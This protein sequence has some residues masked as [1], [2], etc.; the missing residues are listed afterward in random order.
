MKLRNS[1]LFFGV[2]AALTLP[3]LLANIEEKRTVSQ[4]QKAYS[5]LD[6]GFSLAINDLGTVDNWPADNSGYR[7]SYITNNIIP[8]YFKV[9][10]YCPS[11][12]GASLKK[13]CLGF[14]YE[15]LYKNRVNINNAPSFALT[16]GMSIIVY[17]SKSACTQ[18]KNLTKVPLGSYNTA[19]ETFFVDLNGSKGPNVASRD[20]FV[21]HLMQDGIVPAGSAKESIWT[22][23]F[24]EQCLGKQLTNAGGGAYCT[25]WV[26][27]NRNMDYMK[28]DDLSWENKTSCK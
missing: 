20:L 28:C 22:Q 19:C 12:G 18:N 17:G 10:K 25:A 13:P 7:A 24:V 8:K 26:L 16:N 6:E 23:K 21:F 5:L 3:S 11:G 9:A 1:S 4:L 14:G 2:I 27:Y 15:D